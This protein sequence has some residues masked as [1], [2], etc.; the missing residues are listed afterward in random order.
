M[1]P[2]WPLA[3]GLLA[4]WGAGCTKVA[5]LPVDAGFTVADASWFAAEQT[6]FVFYRVSAEQGI[7]DPS[8]I[9][10]TWATDDER[11]DWTPLSD[12]PT[13][14]THEPVACGTKGLCGS[15]SLAIPLEPREV[16]LRL[17][18]HPDGELALDADTVFNVVDEG[19]AHTHRSF[20]VYGVFEETNQRIQWRGRHQ[21]P[22][23]RNH[24]AEGLGLRRYFRVEDQRYGTVVAPGG[25][26]NP[27][28]YGLDCPEDF[29]ATDVGTVESRERA[30]FNGQDLTLEASEQ[31][32]VCG[33]SSVTDATGHFTTNAFGQ[34]N[35]E[36]RPAFPLLRSP[37]RDATPL[38][39]FLEPCDRPLSQEHWEMQRQRL[40]MEGVAPICTDDWDSP[41]FVDSL[42]AAFTDA[43]E[44]ERPS[45]QD[46]VLVVGLH[47]DEDE[48]GVAGALQAA[49]DLVVPEERHRSTPR[50]SGAFVFDSDIEGLTVPTLEP[51]TLWCPAA[52]GDGASGRTCA[53][54]PDNP[55]FE[56][57]PL[58]FNT[59]PVLPSRDIYLDFLETYS[60]R[61]TGDV[62]ALEYLTPEFAAT[63]D[64]IDLGEF[65]T[66]TFLNDEL[67]SAAPEDAFSHCVP[68]APPP[69]VFRSD[70][71][72]SEQFAT[73]LAAWCRN[74]SVS[75]DFCSL[76]QVGVAT[77]DNLPW[78]HAQFGE[79]TYELGL[80]W[81]FPF[82]LR[83]EDEAY[84][85]GSVS[86]LGLSV[87]FGLASDGEAYFGTSAWLA[88]EFELADELTQCKRFC[89][90][91]TFDSAGAYH[92][93]DAF[94]GTYANSC[95][96]PDYP[97]LEDNGFP[98]DP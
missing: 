5:I 91:P 8:A 80:F 40:E 75:E 56:L 10:I 27:Y 69:V 66:I 44:A 55:D 79:D 58:S 36:V 4:L 20:V 16:A 64:H 92:P 72:G 71:L 49:L 30:V 63:T 54:A 88:Q 34:K 78:W 15:S 93:T 7:G 9:E 2:G 51:V 39:F 94:R 29:V 77:L 31:A 23:Q 89:D 37:V 26:D 19:P 48:D 43:V 90:N 95:Y 70:I 46:M 57:G 84:T 38:Q 83:I 53:I 6:L 96:G 82:L 42:V 25:L 97:E 87:P 32:T 1:K 35:P 61:Q 74:G 28:G 47:R 85:A 59:L 24:D 67:I 45:G 81:D 41:A 17:R 62:L 11:V 12:L 65:G 21:F 86:A 3:V 14:H 68:E 33:R 73:A 50:L 52:R 76:A 98:L 60:I 22:T 18:Y 13:V